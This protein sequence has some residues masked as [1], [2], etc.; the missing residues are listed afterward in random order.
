MAATKSGGSKRGF[1]AM[2]PAKQREIASK[3][4][5]AKPRRRPQGQLEP[6]IRPSYQC[7]GAGRSIRPALSHAF[8]RGNARPTMALSGRGLSADL[9]A[10]DKGGAI[11]AVLAIQLALLFVLLHLSGKIDVVDPQSVLKRVRFSEPPPPPPPP[12]PPAAAAKA[13]AEGRAARRRRTSGARRRP[14]VAPKPQVDT[15]PVQQIAASETP[16]QGTAS[17]PGRRRRSRARAPA[18]AASGNGTGSGTGGNGSGGGGDDGVA[19]PPQ[20][21]TP[22]LRGPRLPARHARP[23]AARRDRYSCACGSTRTAMSAECSV[24]RGT[25]VAAIDSDAVQ[26]RARAAALPAR[27]QSQRAGGCRMV[28]IRATSAA[29][30]Q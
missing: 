11:A 12:P 27:A 29:I 2:D 28:R 15:P 23:V 30:I 8:R 25:G 10:R 20:L 9:D 26:P 14:V 13:E 18:P 21:V 22:V 7:E 3:G 4:G 19:E 5:K 16:R 1:A 17:D 6:L 24:D